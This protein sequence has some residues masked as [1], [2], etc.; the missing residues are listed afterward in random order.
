MILTFDLWP[1]T[2]NLA[3]CVRVHISTYLKFYRLCF[4]I[5]RRHGTN[6]RTRCNA[7]CR[8][9]RKAASHHNSVYLLTRAGVPHNNSAYFSCFNNSMLCIRRW[10]TGSLS[11]H[12]EIRSGWPTSFVRYSLYWSRVSACWRHHLDVEWRHSQQ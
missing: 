3:L 7:W 6:R 11:R 5:K 10:T 2:S 4:R 1:L 12:A 8:L 9:L